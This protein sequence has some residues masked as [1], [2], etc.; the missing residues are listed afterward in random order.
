M[1][2]IILL[3]YINW[4]DTI[5]CLESVL[6]LH[7]PAFRI[8][9]VD[10][11]SSNDSLHHIHDWA[12]G[13]GLQ[14]LAPNPQLAHLVYPLIQKPLAYRHLS[15]TEAL[16]VPETTEPLPPLITIQAGENRGFA[17]GN[18]IGISYALKQ[19]DC[20][21]IWLLNND[22][23]VERDALTQL[24]KHHQLSTGNL[25]ILGSKLLYYHEPGLI[26][27]I[28]GKYNKW[29]CTTHHIGGDIKDKGQFDPP[30]VPEADYIVGAS[31]FVS[32]AF[33]EDVG[34]M[35]E[36]YFLYFEELDWTFRG[37][38]KGWSI[39]VCTTSKV[40]HKEG[41][42][43]NAKEKKSELADFYS[44]RNRLVFSKRFFPVALPLIYLSFLGV[45][46]N[47][48]KRGQFRRLGMILKIIFST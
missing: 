10:N 8:I 48:L 7:Y 32:R 11:A 46:L 12:N 22:T 23:L 44:L 34:L 1:V 4:K 27:A 43:I 18:N 42:S 33:V 29:L 17:A 19:K 16:T 14:Q 26:Q 2:Y 41:A 31:M 24:V 3:N 36:D 15:K 5:E 39:G 9:L 37:K 35:R 21:Y 38:Q 28:A 45:A 6:K 30:Y 20:D 47:R 13:S 25:G 40:Y